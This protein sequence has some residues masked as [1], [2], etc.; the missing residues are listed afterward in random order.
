M[1]AVDKCFQVV[2]ESKGIFKLWDKAFD[3]FRLWQIDEEST[4][5]SWILQAKLD[6]QLAE[7]NSFLPKDV[8]PEETSK[9]IEEHFSKLTDSQKLEYGNT[10]QRLTAKKLQITCMNL[11]PLD[12]DMENG[13]YAGI[14]ETKVEFFASCMTHKHD[15]LRVNNFFLKFTN[16]STI[17]QEQSQNQK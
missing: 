8:S 10:V 6:A 14:W 17:S 16:R 3:R 4:A 2:D 1:S 12:P 5:G 15:H 11:T 13:L 9:H 7:L